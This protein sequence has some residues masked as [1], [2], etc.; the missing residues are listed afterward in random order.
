MTENASARLEVKSFA[1]RTVVVTGG[2]GPLGKVLSA[3]FAARGAKVALLDLARANPGEAAGAIA[4]E[5]GATVVGLACDLASESS[6]REAAAAVAAEGPVHALVNNAAFTGAAASAGW[7]VPFEDQSAELW[8]LAVEINLTAP[9]VL[10]QAL[11]PALRAA[12]SAAVLNISSIY[13]LV[14]PD[15]SIY[16]GTTLGNPAAYAASKGGLLQLTRWMATTLAPAVRVNALALGGIERGQGEDFLRAYCRRAPMG[17]MA[18][19][20][21]IVGP[22]LFMVSDQSAYVTGQVLP[23]DGGWTAW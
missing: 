8:R 11:L 14:G 18:A 21:D 6:V 13:G 5:H 3:A 1:G 20:D 12:G 19:E 16:A 15:W 17:R 4:A 2:A 23:V 9:F 7:A 10:T 22:A